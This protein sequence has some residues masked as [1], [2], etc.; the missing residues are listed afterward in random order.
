MI[1]AF[2]LYKFE[3]FKKNNNS[4]VE[5]YKKMIKHYKNKNIENQK[6]LN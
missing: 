2:T 3:E 4:L 5:I 1:N 6:Y